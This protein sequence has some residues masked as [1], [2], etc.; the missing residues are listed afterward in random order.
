MAG[1][2]VHIPFC[3]SRCIYCGFY[4][5]TGKENL[6][7]RYI[8]ALIK[9]YRQRK[10]YLKGDKVRTIY[11]GGGT[12]S[13]LSRDSLLRIKNGILSEIDI[14]SI[15]EFTIE[16]NPD[17]ITPDFVK[18]LR[19][20]C[21]TRVSMGAQ[22]FSDE[23]LRFLNR[24]HRSGQIPEAVML[25]REAG[26]K[27]I[28]IDLM[29]GFPK[30][31]L[32]EWEKD[33][34]TALALDVEHLSAYS[35]MYEEG[36][37]LYRK[38][39]SGEISEIDEELSAKMYEMLIDKL[40][41]AGFEHYEISNFAKAGYRSKHNSSYWNGTWYLGLGAAAHSYDGKTRGWNA[42]NI[43]GYIKFIEEK[44]ETGDDKG[45]CCQAMDYE[46]IDEATSY[47][48]II[49]TALRTREGIDLGKLADPYNI[50]ILR[51]A[52]K[53]INKG[54]LEFEDNHLRLTR[55][56]LFV[57]DDVMSDLIYVD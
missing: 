50:Y 25:L 34:E 5:T 32:A 51:Y 23:R 13:L 14:K 7:E 46:V 52:R 56:G 2:Y 19:E 40:T 26:I 54:L 37:T 57:S 3:A 36:T 20:L 30:E 1:I 10:N 8:D 6:Q 33:I 17:D 12:P 18:T 29:F 16:C 49:T 44:P 53:A 21:V 28:S 47:N 42:D 43:E 15:E 24:R 45:F 9:E 27:N 39:E 48:D 22:T 31:T 41:D 11:I 35:L 38:K 55:Q 4:S